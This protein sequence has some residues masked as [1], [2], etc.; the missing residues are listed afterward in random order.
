MVRNAVNLV[1]RVIFLFAAEPGTSVS[2]LTHSEESWQTHCQ[3][4]MSFVPHDQESVSRGMTLTVAARAR[5]SIIEPR[6]RLPWYFA[7]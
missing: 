3:V 2:C 4:F 1:S 5:T 6:Y 7:R